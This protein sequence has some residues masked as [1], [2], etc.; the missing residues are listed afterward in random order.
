MKK[1]SNNYEIISRRQFFKKAAGLVLPAI[2]LTALPSI[3]TS[4]EIDEPLE[5]GEGGEGGGNSTGGG[6]KNG[7]KSVCTRNC[8]STCRGTAIYKPS[9]CNS[10]CKGACTQ[11]CKSSCIRTSFN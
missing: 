11:T 3:L 6:C 8:A 10:S 2:A 4:C 9:S 7:C 1:K 5:G